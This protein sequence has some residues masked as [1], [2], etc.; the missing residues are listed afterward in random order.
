MDPIYVFL[1]AAE[2]DSLSSVWTGIMLIR[3]QLKT[4]GVKTINEILRLRWRND[5]IS[6]FT[7]AHMGSPSKLIKITIS[8]LDGGKQGIA[9]TSMFS[10]GTN[11]A[12]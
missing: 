4:L 2:P 3:A 11:A 5:V 12:I 6:T 1:P 9:F 10:L 8:P 7:Q